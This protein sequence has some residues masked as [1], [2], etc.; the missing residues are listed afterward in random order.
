[1]RERLEDVLAS[2]RADADVLKRLGHPNEAAHLAGVCDRV[3]RA[4]VEFLTWIGEPDACVMAGHQVPWLRSRFPALEARGHA[5]IRRGRRYYRE[6]VLQR[7]DRSDAT[8]HRV[9]DEGVARLRRERESKTPPRQ[10]PTASAQ[11]KPPVPPWA[12]TP[13]R[14]GL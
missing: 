7:E 2:V 5:E 6:C 11:R 9:A 12:R 10:T 3:E 1:M 4:A 8:A 13:G 14:R